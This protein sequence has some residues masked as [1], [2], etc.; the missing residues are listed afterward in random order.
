M[1]RTYCV[2]FIVSSCR[3][4]SH[5]GSRRSWRNSSVSAVLVKLSKSDNRKTSSVSMT[6]THKSEQE[7]SNLLISKSTENPEPECTEGI[8]AP[9]RKP[10]LGRHQQI[11]TDLTRIYTISHYCTAHPHTP[12]ILTCYFIAH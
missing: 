3:A 2:L 10:R 6:R 5:N 9:C 11:L 8:R 12:R 4:V 1:P 7:R